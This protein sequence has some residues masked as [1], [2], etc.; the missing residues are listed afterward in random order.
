MNNSNPPL[1]E[2]RRLTKSFPISNSLFGLKKERFEVLKGINLTIHEGEIVG[3]VGESGSGKSTLGECIGGLQ[4]CPTDSIF[5][6]GKD[7]TKLSK[8]E[9][10]EYRRSVQFIFQHPAETLNPRLTLYH[11]IEEPMIVAGIYSTRQERRE[12]VKQLLHDVG[13]NENLLES[14]PG[15]L[16]G[17]QAQR[18]AIARALSVKPKLLICDEAV[19]SLDLSVQANILNLLADLQKTYQVSQLFISHDLHVVQYLARYVAVIHQGLIVESGVSNEVL[20]KPKHPYTQ[21]LI[22]S[23][24]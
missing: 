19:S 13:L 2:V 12:A 23:S 14:H 22:E 9:Y 4:S 20:Q 24:L 8:I 3:L 10:K 18:V 5:F 17:G 21:S 1:L 11:I 15:R 16:S 6:R 7:I